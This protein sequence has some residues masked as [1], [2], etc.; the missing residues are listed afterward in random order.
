M[1]A[2]PTSK[3]PIHAATPLT[4]FGSVAPNNQPKSTRL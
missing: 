2:R 4:I 1:I 3:I